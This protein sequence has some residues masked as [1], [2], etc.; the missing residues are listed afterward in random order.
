MLILGHFDVSSASAVNS[1][2]LW[3]LC[4]AVVLLLWQLCL[5]VSTG[6]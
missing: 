2:L 4:L 6:D 5:R 3:K 1:E